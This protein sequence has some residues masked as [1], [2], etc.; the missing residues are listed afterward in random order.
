VYE[1]TALEWSQYYSEPEV[2][3]YWYDESTGTYN[4]ETEEP[5]PSV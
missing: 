4:V 3:V 2:D 1:P 5:S